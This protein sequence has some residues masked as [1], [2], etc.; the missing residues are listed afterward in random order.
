LRYAHIFCIVLPF[1]HTQSPIIL[2]NTRQKRDVEMSDNFLQNDSCGNLKSSYI[3]HYVID[4]FNFITK[5][6]KA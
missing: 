4:N 2:S 1:N 6:P 5:S 3:G